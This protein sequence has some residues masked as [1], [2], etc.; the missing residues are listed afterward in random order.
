MKFV[1][2]NDPCFCDYTA[3]PFVMSKHHLKIEFDRGKKHKGKVKVVTTVD[4]QVGNFIKG[5][6]RSHR[7]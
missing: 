6:V 5:K 3:L 4:H 1:F 2:H 7:R